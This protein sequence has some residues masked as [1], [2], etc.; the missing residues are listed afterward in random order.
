MLYETHCHLNS[1]QL[2][3]DYAGYIN[4]ALAAGV[5][6][7]NVVGY[8]LESS[9]K[10]IEI[11]KQ[12]PFVYAVVGIGPEDC[13]ETT[14]EDLKKLE[15]LLEDENVV[16]LGEIGLDYHWDT[17]PKEKQWD[18]FEKQM[19]LA[20]KHHLP[21]MIHSRDALKDTYDLL[22]QHGVYGNMHCYSGSVEMAKEFVKLGFKISLGGPVT[23]KNA[24]VPKLV[25]QEID[26]KDLLI[27][28]DS[29][30]L[31]PHPFR[32]QL[33]DPSY[34]VYVAKEIAAIKNMSEE[35]V[36]KQTC[37]N[38]MALFGVKDTNE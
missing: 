34:I 27:E 9:K 1:H 23:F 3:D 30:Y 28:T 21:V 38:A 31:T 29:P 2:Y 24:K 12:Y 6:H 37:L 26:L 17:V 16:A 20:K 14:D 5:T 8:S 11:A 22:K 36:M 33:N 19:E 18:I 4:K 10:A 35:E 7:L 25:A 32:G 15:L 13:L